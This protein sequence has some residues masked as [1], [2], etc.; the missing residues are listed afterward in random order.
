M[1]R[2]S[3]AWSHDRL[4]GKRITVTGQSEGSPG[5]RFP[6]LPPCF[7]E[8][9]AHSFPNRGTELSKQGSQRWGKL[10]VRLILPALLDLL[11]VCYPIGDFCDFLGVEFQHDI[12]ELQHP[13]L[14]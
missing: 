11:K 3:L 5:P 14:P 8:A 10:L 4:E 2:R 1:L 9:V 13:S 7:C 6:S 12:A